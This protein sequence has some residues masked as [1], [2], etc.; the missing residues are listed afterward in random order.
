MTNHSRRFGAVVREARE[1]S[2]VTQ[3]DLAA[4][5]GVKQPAV[6]AWEGNKAFPTPGSLVKL[7]DEL[8]LELADLVRLIAAEQQDG[9]LVG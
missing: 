3:V 8:N 1:A 6:S 4:R 9:E 5:L 2:E 7:A